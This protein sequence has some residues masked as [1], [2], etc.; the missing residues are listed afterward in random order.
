MSLLLNDK[1]LTIEPIMDF[2][3]DK[4]VRII[5]TA[6]PKQVN[7]G[8]DTGNNG[9]PEP[10]KEKVLQLIEEIEKFTTIHNKNNL[11]RLLI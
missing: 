11:K 8:A 5:K 4:L 10:S 9:L 3:L 2:D 6:K 7:I 1:Y